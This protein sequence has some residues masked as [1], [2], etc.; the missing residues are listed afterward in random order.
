MQRT[1][2][3]GRSGAG[4]SR[5]QTD[6]AARAWCWGGPLP[7]LGVGRWGWGTWGEFLPPSLLIFPVKDVGG[8]TKEVL[9]PQEATQHPKTWGDAGLGGPGR[10]LAESRCTYLLA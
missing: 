4:G 2:K 7:A 8:A 3:T 9:R 6:G 10:C 5:E 1:G